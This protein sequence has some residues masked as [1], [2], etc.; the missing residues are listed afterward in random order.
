RD[1]LVSGD[2]RLVIVCPRPGL[3]GVVE[4]PAL[5][6][7]WL[8]GGRAEASRGFGIVA[9]R[10]VDRPSEDVEGLLFAYACS[11]GPG[12]AS[13]LLPGHLDLALFAEGSRSGESLLFR[14][15]RGP[16]PLRVLVRVFGRALGGH[17]RRQPAKIGCGGP[18]LLQGNQWLCAPPRQVGRLVAF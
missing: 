14:Q 17:L 4:E 2:G 5:V 9:A 10:H 1:L 13:Q 6:G 15:R 8:G 3:G 12:E 7:A 16:E 11:W 18:G